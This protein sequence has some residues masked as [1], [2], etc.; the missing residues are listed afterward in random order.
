MI[1]RRVFILVLAHLADE[2]LELLH[3]ILPYLLLH[4]MFDG[5]VSA[6]SGRQF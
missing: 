6:Q 1:F 3:G 5:R 2:A 4:I